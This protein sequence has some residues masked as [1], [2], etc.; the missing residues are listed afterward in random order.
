MARPIRITKCLEWDSAHRLL[1]HES[2]CASLH[3]HRYQAEVTCEAERLDAIGRVV[4]FAVINEVLG[5]WLDTHWDHTTLVNAEDTD[6][7]EFLEAEVQRGKRKHYVF[8]GEPTVEHITQE[9]FA[10]ACR[11]L[12][13]D[14]V[15]VTKIRVYETPDSW[16]EI[17]ADNG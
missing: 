6:L 12:N 1:R 5:N 7:I 3:G 4:D 17:T 16:A 13:T 14:R 9:L 2:K 8:Q 11:V 10:V 15:R